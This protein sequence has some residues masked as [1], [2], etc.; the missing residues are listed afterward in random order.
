MYAGIMQTELVI[1]RPQTTGQQVAWCQR[2]LNSIVDWVDEINLLWARGPACT[3]E[4]GRTVAAAKCQLPRGGWSQMWRKPYSAPFGKRKGEMFARIGKNLGHLT[5]QTSAQLPR[6]WTILYHLA[7]LD[8]PTLDNLLGDG[9]IHP[10]LTLAEAE[11]LV[12]SFRGKPVDAKS[13]D[14]N[15]KL[16]LKNLEEFVLDTLSEWSVEDRELAR[17]KLIELAERI[18]AQHRDSRLVAR[19]DLGRLVSFVARG[20]ESVGFPS[21][22]FEKSSLGLG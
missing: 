5:A 8:R 4:L 1:E 17:P 12:A 21:L 16:R 20:S 7:L 10:K 2:A 22:E 18:G 14:V 19:S 3:I 15:V 9:T 11:S 13:K 6:G